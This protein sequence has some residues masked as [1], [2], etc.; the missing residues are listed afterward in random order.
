MA[1]SRFDAPRQSMQFKPLSMQEMAF[2]PTL[3]R[4][5]EDVMQ[6]Q[7]DIASETLGD[8]NIPDE[9]VQNIVGKWDKEL[10]DV[11]EQ[12]VRSGYSPEMESKFRNLKRRYSQDIKP[13]QTY[14]AARQQ[15]AVDYNKIARDPSKHIEGVVPTGI[16]YA[17]FRED[18]SQLQNYQVF[19]KKQVR[20]DAQGAAKRLVDM[21]VG[22]PG[23]IKK[24]VPG[25]DGYLQVAQQKGFDAPEAVAQW[26]TTDEGGAYLQSN[27]QSH[28]YAGSGAMS[29]LFAQELI[30][31][32]Y[33]APE[34]RLIQDRDYMTAAQRAKGL[35]DR[36]GDM[37]QGI[38]RKALDLS[39]KT[40]RENLP[41]LKVARE[42]SLQEL[43]NKYPLLEDVNTW[44]DLTAIRE[45]AEKELPV[46]KVRAPGAIFG[47]ARALTAR[48]QQAADLMDEIEGVAV[49]SLKDLDIQEYSLDQ[50]SNISSKSKTIVDNAAKAINSTLANNLKHLSAMDDAQDTELT[51]LKEKIAD[52]TISGQDLKMS[53]KTVT[54]PTDIGGGETQGSIYKVDIKAGTG[55]DAVFINDVDITAD[56]KVTELINQSDKFF[57][58]LDKTPTFVIARKASEYRPAVEQAIA[59]NP[60]QTP[61]QI[62]KGVIGKG[63][64]AEIEN[65]RAVGQAIAKVLGIN[66][67]ELGDVSNTPFNSLIR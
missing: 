65:A 13:I 32:G 23:F 64:P 59:T 56:E 29:Q 30:N 58:T 61:D 15:A 18:P 9:D 43:K 8:I 22:D 49:E 44:K 5:K 60:N 54:K 47:G 48:T 51:G 4:Q 11:S 3:M 45:K 19:D 31:Y 41:A 21:A 39:S 25:L 1:I 46:T 50:L 33:K 34:W 6:G 16:S 62:L 42:R 40:V 10:S 52:G 35:A 57:D 36:S 17:Q 12:M 26:L 66:V 28:G 24:N 55:K 20:M 38:G 7:I 2:A 67:S 53:L 37:L 14:M 27:L 63:S